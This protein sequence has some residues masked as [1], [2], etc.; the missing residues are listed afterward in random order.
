MGD[1][2]RAM[3]A[4]R[5]FMPL[6][7]W[8]R[9]EV[10]A[11]LALSDAAEQ[12]AFW[13]ERLDT[14]RFRAAFDVLTSPRILRAVYAP[15]FLSVLPEGFGAV[16]RRRLERGFARHP[17]ATNP[18]AR[19]LLLGEYPPAPRPAHP[20]ELLCAD[21]AG[22]LESSPRGSFDG[23]TVSNVLDGA[24]AEYRARLLAAVRRTATDGA[25]LVVR[26]FA[27]PE[28]PSPDNVAADDRS[29]LWG[30]VHVT[31]PASTSSNRR[32]GSAP[33]EAKQEA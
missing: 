12:M 30:S 4:A 8:R 33:S 14:R 15:R 18:Y 11:F 6:V 22:Y 26:S 2:E 16:L 13:R 5:M 23:F 20:V 1:V 9:G 17:N 28:R 3:N 7:G 32:E 10:R 24:P 29:M 31:E 25:R 19:A 21:A 27:E